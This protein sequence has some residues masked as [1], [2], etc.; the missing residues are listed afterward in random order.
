MTHSRL[1][2]AATVYAALS[3]LAIG[4]AILRDDLNLYQHPDPL[5]RL[6]LVASIPLGLATGLAVGLFVA[7]LTRFAVRRWPPVRALHVEFRALFGPLTNG[8]IALFA[9]FSSV[10]EELFFRGALLPASGLAISSLLFGLMHL[11]PKRRLVPWT[12]SALVMGF[13]LG[14][15]FVLTGDLTAPLVAHFVVNYENLQFI[16]SYDPAAAV[17]SR[18]A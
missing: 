12:V 2:F 16:T 14:G 10:G 18:P 6:P 15:L 13:V 4:W 1:R 11:A 5:V 8:E 17:P 9:L 7:F 3:A